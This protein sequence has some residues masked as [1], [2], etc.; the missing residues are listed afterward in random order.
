[1]GKS[2]SSSSAK[3]GPA[4]SNRKAIPRKVTRGADGRLRRR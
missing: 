4:K 3:G 2:K 1:M